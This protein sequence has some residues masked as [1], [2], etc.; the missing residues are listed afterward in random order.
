MKFFYVENMWMCLRMLQKNC[1]L[2]DCIVIRASF[3]FVKALWGVT[4]TPFIKIKLTSILISYRYFSFG[5][6][7]KKSIWENLC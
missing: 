1:D 3:I 5:L 4:T 6:H 7:K 2:F